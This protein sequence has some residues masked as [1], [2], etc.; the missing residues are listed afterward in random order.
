MYNQ[1]QIIENRIDFLKNQLE[2]IQNDFRTNLKPK[3]NNYQYKSLTKMLL[4]NIQ[5]DIDN[6]LERN[7]LRISVYVSVLNQNL[8][9]VGLTL[10]DELVWENIQ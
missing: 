1:D 2:T 7:D 5:N 3:L 6:F 8:I 10:I 4:K 9:V